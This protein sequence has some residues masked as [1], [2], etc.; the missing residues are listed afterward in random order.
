MT[1][2]LPDNVKAL[3]DAPTFVVLTTINADGSPHATVLWIRRDGDDLVFSTV[4]GRQK[5]RN[6]ERDPRVSVCAYDPA[7]PY[8]YFSVN[9]EVTLTEEGGRELIDELSVKYTGG[10]YTNDGPDVV[11]VVC[12]LTPHRVL[13]G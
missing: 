1:T 9:G 7:Q 5:T 2:T 12:R 10:P 3:L 11:R 8:S 6:M 13:G 4:R